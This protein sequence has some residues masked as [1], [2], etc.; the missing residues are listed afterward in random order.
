MLLA[1]SPVYLWQS[2]HSNVELP[3]PNLIGVLLSGS[4]RV[5]ALVSPIDQKRVTDV[6]AI[7]NP[8]GTWGV[9]FGDQLD[10][11]MGME[12]DPDTY[13]FSTFDGKRWRSLEKLPKP[14]GR[15]R[16]LSATKLVRRGNTLYLAVPVDYPRLNDAVAL[17]IREDGKWRM[18]EKRLGIAGYLALDTTSTGTLLLGVVAVDTTEKSDENSLFL[19]ELRSS[20]KEWVSKGR[21]VKGAGRPVHHPEFVWSGHS[22]IAGWLSPSPQGGMEAN[23]LGISNPWP[24][25]VRISSSGPQEFSVLDAGYHDSSAIVVTATP[26]DDGLVKVGSVSEGSYRELYS[27]A[28]PFDGIRAVSTAGSVSLIGPVH[29]FNGR[30]PIVTSVRV[31]FDVVCRTEEHIKTTNHREVR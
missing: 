12:R 23:V 2:T 14:G 29:S 10:R 7:A 17:F 8:D 21:L 9:L 1:G 15:I 4:G 20:G 16:S 24:A 22:L 27:F 30:A 31:R 19:Y 6:R 28:N 25:P 5:K 3:N 18:E 26:G 13:W 11:S